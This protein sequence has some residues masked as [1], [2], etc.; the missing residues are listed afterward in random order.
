MRPPDPLDDLLN[1]AESVE[2]GAVR[3]WLIALRDGDA[4]EQQQRETGQPRQ[5]AD[6]SL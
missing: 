4:S 1:R 6:P 2:D 5:V 3:Q